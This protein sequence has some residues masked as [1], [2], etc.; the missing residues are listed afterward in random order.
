[1]NGISTKTSIGHY[2]YGIRPP[3]EGGW[4]NYK[5]KLVGFFNTIYTNTSLVAHLNSQMSDYGISWSKVQNGDIVGLDK[6]VLNPPTPN[7]G[8]RRIDAVNG[9]VICF[10]RLGYKYTTS[11]SSSAYILRNAGFIGPFENLVLDFQP[12]ENINIYYEIK[13]AI[14]QVNGSGAPNA[15]P[16]TG[17]SNGTHLLSD[18]I[19]QSQFKNPNSL[20]YPN[21]NINLE[22]VNDQMQLIQVIIV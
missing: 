17:T 11:P 20:D 7:T 2:I 9:D 15:F 5:T 1:M 18:L 14:I 21:M 19:Q 6:L 13:C 10:R 4:S 22:I 3:S 12:I 16:E 8:Y